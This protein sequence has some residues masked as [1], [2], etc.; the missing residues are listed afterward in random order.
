MLLSEGA[1]TP[2]SML[3]AREPQHREH[4]QIEFDTRVRDDS[5]ICHSANPWANIVSSPIGRVRNIYRSRRNPRRTTQGEIVIK[6]IVM[7]N[8][9]GE[10]PAKKAEAANLVKSAF[11][12]LNGKISGMRKLEIGID[13]S[14]IDY[15]CD[16]VLYSEFDSREALQ[17]YATHPEHLRVRDEVAGVRTDRYQVDYATSE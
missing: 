2:V 4:Y 8:V 17:A 10:S 14:R 7:W 5:C 16:V 11:E 9:R 6:H 12:D 3:R 15:A 13:I 1:Y